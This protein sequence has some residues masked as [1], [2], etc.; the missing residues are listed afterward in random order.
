MSHA[1]AN[2]RILSSATTA[3]ASENKSSK[4]KWNSNGATG[5]LLFHLPKQVAQP[6]CSIGVIVGISSCLIIDAFR[7]DPLLAQL[8]GTTCSQRTR[9][10][11]EGGRAVVRLEHGE[12]QKR[13]V[14]C[15]DN[16]RLVILRRDSAKDSTM[17][18][19]I[20][21]TPSVVDNHG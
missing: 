13:A 10:M 8:G 14:G 20:S 11:L 18:G 9:C 19:R 3:A 1:S 12:P 7:V 15:L 17:L 2:E 6:Q 4:A 21:M 16:Q 5:T